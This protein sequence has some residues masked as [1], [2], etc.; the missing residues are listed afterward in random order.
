MLAVAPEATAGAIQAS[1]VRPARRALAPQSDVVGVYHVIEPAGETLD[2]SLEVAV[3][4]RGDLAAALADQ[5]VVVVAAGVDGLVAGDALRHVD[6]ARQLQAIEQLEGP[7]D[8]RHAHVL[9]ALAEAVRD[10]LCGD[11]APEVGQRLDH[12]GTGVA[13]PVAAP[14]ERPLRVSDPLIHGAKDRLRSAGETGT[15]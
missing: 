1:F 12:D 11:A 7:V 6:A 14:L 3:L 5:V 9:A 4:E 8:A 13:Q 15:R 10:L 2:R